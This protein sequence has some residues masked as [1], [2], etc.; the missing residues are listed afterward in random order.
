[1]G[2]RLARSSVRE[3]RFLSSASEQQLVQGGMYGD[4]WFNSASQGV[5]VPAALVAIIR[6]L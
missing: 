5:R 4:K 3:V 1:M 6:A 2:A